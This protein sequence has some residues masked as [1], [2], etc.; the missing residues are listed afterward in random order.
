MPSLLTIPTEILQNIIDQVNPDDLI[1]FSV[2]CKGLYGVA[3]RHLGK[4]REQ[5]KTYSEL[6]YS[7]C[8]RHEDDN[9]PIKILREI[10][11]DDHFAFYPRSLTITCCEYPELMEEPDDDEDLLEEELLIKNLDG[12]IVRKVFAEFESAIDE[13]LSRALCYNDK[14]IEGWRH[15]LKSGTRGG[16]LCLL[17]LLLPNLEILHLTH[18]GF[19]GDILE[20]ILD[21]IATSL[22]VL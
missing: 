5:I 1:S 6:K 2:C 15:R 20:D 21:L 16:V 22:L 9:H 11:R 8:F 3:E 10:C 18:F 17:L 14:N 7:G 12:E 4:H 13:K 19:E